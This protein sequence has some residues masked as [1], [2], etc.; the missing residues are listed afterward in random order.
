MEV[1]VASC[2]VIDLVVPK[3]PKR[4][5]SS[6]KR[7][8]ITKTLPYWKVVPVMARAQCRACGATSKI[9]VNILGDEWNC[10][11]NCANTDNYGCGKKNADGT[12][13]IP[14]SLEMW[15]FKK[16]D[17]KVGILDVVPKICY[18]GMIVEHKEKD[19]V[20]YW[21]G[22][23]QIRVKDTK[24]TKNLSALQ[25]ERFRMIQIMKK[26]EVY[27]V[28]DLDH[29]AAEPVYI[30]PYP[31]H[32]SLAL[33]EPGRAWHHVELNP[34]HRRSMQEILKILAENCC[35]I[36]IV[37]DKMH[38]I[39]IPIHPNLPFNAHPQE[40]ATFVNVTYAQT[41]IELGHTTGAM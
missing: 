17:Q 19:V 25:N 41:E 11:K 4:R 6:P 20:G 9:E 22:M 38:H 12:A 26:S 5:D 32:R 2:T 18:T 21:C 10:V 29:T 39:E 31:A 8:N 30:G 7:K 34:V 33:L 28:I 13:L 23:Y 27:L 3:T 35:A 36:T 1:P 14:Y 16:R 15:L 37:I 24:T 40:I